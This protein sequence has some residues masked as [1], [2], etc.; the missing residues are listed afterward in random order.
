MA[1]GGA[2]GGGHGSAR[3]ERATYCKAE[4]SPLAWRSSHIPPQQSWVGE[5]DRVS[6]PLEVDAL[7][8]REAEQVAAQAVEAELD[9]AGAHPLATADQA[10]LARHHGVGVGDADGDGATEIGLGFPAPTLFG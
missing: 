4:Q 5:H 9:G 6:S 1:T 2:G 8:D 10:G 7:V 3:R